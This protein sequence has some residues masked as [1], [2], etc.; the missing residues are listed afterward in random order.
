MPNLIEYVEILFGT[1]LL[2]AV[3]VPINA[4]YKEHELGYIIENADLDILITTDL[5]AGH[6]DFVELVRVRL[7]G[8]GETANVTQLRLS[9]RAASAFGRC[10]RSIPARRNALAGTVRSGRGEDQRGRD[11]AARSEGGGAQCVHHDVHV[12]YHRP[13]ERLPSYSRG[14]GAQRSRHEPA[15]F[16]ADRRRCVLGSATDVSHVGDPADHRRVRRRRNFPVDDACRTRRR[17]QP[18]S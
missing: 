16:P 4:R 18:R 14:P 8:I 7:P 9:L 6:V 3:A 15:T 11:L 17:N 1:A 13:S 10:I 5:A 2:G 12:R